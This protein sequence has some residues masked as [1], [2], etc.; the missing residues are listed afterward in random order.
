M[1]A[2]SVAACHLQFSIPVLFVSLDLRKAFG[3]VDHS[4]LFEGLRHCGLPDGYIALLQQL[5]ADQHGSANRSDAFQIKR[6]VKQGDVLS[7]L[8]F[9]YI[10]DFAMA[11]WKRRNPGCGILVGDPNERLTNSRYA[12]DI[13]I[14][15]KNFR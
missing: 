12:D 13:L 1:I 11:K 5:Y 2:E 14:Y 7:S 15:A 10:L 3:R 8:L 4:A 6:G 9:N